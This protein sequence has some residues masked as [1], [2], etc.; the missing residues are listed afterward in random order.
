[1]L[2]SSSNDDYDNLPSNIFQKCPQPEWPTAHFH[3][4]STPIL[5]LPPRKCLEPWHGRCGSCKWKP[6]IQISRYFFLFAFNG[7][8]LFFISVLGRASLPHASSYSIS[9]FGVEAFSD[10]LRREL[11]SRGVKVSVIEPGF[12]KTNITNKE[13]LQGMWKDLWAKL[14]PNLKE[15]YGYGFYQTSKKFYYTLCVDISVVTPWLKMIPVKW[16][17]II[18][19]QWNDI[20][21]LHGLNCPIK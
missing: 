5:S 3:C 10:A 18:S 17:D 7:Y 12:F 11:K 2:V 19:L 1:M 4:P 15:E 9:K 6:R 8:D 20:I 14:D 16:Y 13:N 21:S